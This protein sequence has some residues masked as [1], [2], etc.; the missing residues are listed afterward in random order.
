MGGSSFLTTH[1]YVLS[2]AFVT[3]SSRFCALVYFEHRTALSILRMLQLF[4]LVLFWSAFSLPHHKASLHHPTDSLFHVVCSPDVG[5]QHRYFFGLASSE[6]NVF[7]LVRVAFLF[8]QFYCCC[9]RLLS[10]LHPY[11]F[12]IIVMSSANRVRD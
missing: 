7:F 12:P 10:F 11:L 2:T 5:S 3:G 4:W 8:E 9:D 1:R 6:L